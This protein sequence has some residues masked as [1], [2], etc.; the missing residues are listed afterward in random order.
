MSQKNLKIKVSSVS[1]SKDDTLRQKLL[2]HFPESEFNPSSHILNEDE[3]IR[4]L[5]DCDGCIVGAEPLS[6]RVLAALPKLQAIAKYGVGLDNIDLQAA[7]HLGKEFYFTPGVN[8]RSVAELCL[9]FMLGLTHNLLGSAFEVKQGLWIKNGGIQLSQKTVGIIGCGHIG[10]ELVALLKPFQC[11]ILINDIV[12]KSSFCRDHQAHQV[13]LSELISKSD[14][15]SLHVPLTAETKDFISAKEFAAMKRTCFLINTSRGHVIDQSALIEA[16][17][18]K[19]IAGAAVDVL[20]VEP[21]NDPD[22]TRIANIFITPHIAGNSKEAVE[23]MGQA[24]ID[25]LVK[26]FQANLRH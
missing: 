9:G 15:I 16:L 25:G 5:Q 4:F 18:A 1:F 7:K 21:P 8:R 17:Q 26:H 3:T 19:T 20:Q 11:N 23:A 12:D 13:P 24:A 22:L 6:Q 2:R 14:I 10:S